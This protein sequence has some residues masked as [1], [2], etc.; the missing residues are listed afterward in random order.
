M[1]SRARQ[2]L[3]AALSGALLMLPAHTGIAA[4]DTTSAAGKVQNIAL[5]KTAADVK[6]VADYWKPEKFKHTDSYS[7]ATPG[8]AAAPKS[9]SA[10]SQPKTL[11]LSAAFC[12]F[13]AAT[14]PSRAGSP[15]AYT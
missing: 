1:I 10:G 4:A 9:T 15:V 3:A 14:V 2:L 13:T 7:P 12:D 6:R 8:A 5:A 11:T